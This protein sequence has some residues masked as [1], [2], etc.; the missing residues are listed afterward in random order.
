MTVSSQAM[1]EEETEHHVNDHEEEFE[2]A[3]EEATERE[4][5]A[6]LPRSLDDRK[7]LPSY[8][9]ETEY[10]DGWQGMH[11]DRTSRLPR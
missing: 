9:Q 10:Y 4:L 7:A 6:D 5:P 2:D 1:E 3:P 8:G 11:G